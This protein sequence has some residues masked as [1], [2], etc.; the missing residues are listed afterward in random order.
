MGR[1]RS[2]KPELHS[3]PHIASLPDF[4]WRTYVGIY[5]LVDDAGHAP[6]DP[7]YVRA[8]LF[9]AHDV[10]LADVQGALSLL[11]ERGLI[12]LYA[13][14]GAA[15][16]EVSGWRVK[17][18]IAYQAIDHPQLP[19]YP[20]PNSANVPRTLAEDSTQDP[21]RSDPKGKDQFAPA[22]DGAA[23]DSAPSGL[24]EGLRAYLDGDASARAWAIGERRGL[25]MDRELERFRAWVERE[26]IRSK[27]WD[28]AFCT[29][30]EKSKDTNRSNG[31]PCADREL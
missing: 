18:S 14:D 12:D 27:D 23:T 11:A 3:T 8:Q 1:I 15:Y 2:I 19:K 28:K 30:L 25:D 7:A 9:W 29:W 20:L 16:L 13:A 17:G 10:T 26:G 6:A 31:H 4:A 21:I 22:P 5:S 24:P